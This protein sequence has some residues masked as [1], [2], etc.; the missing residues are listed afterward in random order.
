MD[1]LPHITV[2]VRALSGAQYR[3]FMTYAPFVIDCILQL[4]VR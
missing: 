3:V 1:M 2:L 4:R